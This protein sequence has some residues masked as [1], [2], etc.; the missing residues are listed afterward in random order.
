[1]G[2]AISLVAILQLA[3]QFYHRINGQPNP[4]WGKI[5]ARVLEEIGLGEDGLDEYFE[6]ISQRFHEAGC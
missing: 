2:A 3:I 6:D 4:V 5:G 1:L